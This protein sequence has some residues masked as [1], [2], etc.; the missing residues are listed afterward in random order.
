MKIIAYLW[1]IAVSAPALASGN[2]AAIAGLAAFVSLVVGAIGGA[3]AGWFGW[4]H[5]G[6]MPVVVAV[7]AL[8]LLFARPQD[9]RE[10]VI[11]LLF[12]TAFVSIIP[13]A[14]RRCK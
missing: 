10:G 14:L 13:L 3:L 5:S 1:L 11:G 6:V 7:S 2:E 12:L 9:F 4:R 8:F